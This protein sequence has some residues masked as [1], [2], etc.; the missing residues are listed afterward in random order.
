[1]QAAHGDW[2]WSASSNVKICQAL[3]TWSTESGY[4]GFNRIS[5]GEVIGDWRDTLEVVN[6]ELSSIENHIAD[7]VVK[8]SR[9]DAESLCATGDGDEN[10][11]IEFTGIK[12]NIS[13]KDLIAYMTAD[14]PDYT[15]AINFIHG[16]YDSQKPTP[17]AIKAMKRIL[18]DV[19]CEKGASATIVKLV[20]PKNT[21]KEDLDYL[22]ANADLSRGNVLIGV[23]NTL[24]ALNAN[25]GGIHYPK[26]QMSRKSGVNYFLI[27]AVREH[28][29]ALFDGEIVNHDS[30][31]GSEGEI[32]HAYR[33]KWESSGTL[34]EREYTFKANPGVRDWRKI[35]SVLFESDTS[36][37]FTAFFSEDKEG[38]GP[39]EIV[40]KKNCVKIRPVISS[41]QIKALDLWRI[42]NHGDT[43]TDSK[44]MGHSRFQ[45]YLLAI[46]AGYT[47][48]ETGDSVESGA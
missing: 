20:E 4:G 41:E 12:Y 38:S 9:E 44:I 14:M 13:K 27:N 45:D 18:L 34:E 22:A 46:K 26:D 11:F 6:R 15:I 32:F 35:H 24:S 1:M 21:D 48:T 19:C 25:H 33:A 10:K 8:K 40:A 3:K 2:F 7:S 39:R 17:D 36:I 37:V 28:R 43:D 23:V 30:K 16:V 31:K 29:L 47:K 42:I 5:A